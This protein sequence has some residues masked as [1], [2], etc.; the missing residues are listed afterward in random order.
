MRY[1]WSCKRLTVGKPLFCNHCGKS[2]DV[3]YCPRLHENPRG[4]QACSQCGSRDLS[5]P[6]RHVPWWR[7]VTIM[8]FNL[9]GVT[10]LILTVL[11]GVYM[12][13]QV[14]S[15]PYG[16]LRPMLLGLLLALLWLLYVIV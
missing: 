13:F 12:G 14:L 3:K 6:Q 10:L 16:L 15:D 11:Y 9:S 1:C 7:K 8:L 5:L 2:Y 4:A